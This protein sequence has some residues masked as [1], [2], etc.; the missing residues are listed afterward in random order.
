MLRGLDALVTLISREAVIYLKRVPRAANLAPLSKTSSCQSPV[1]GTSPNQ[2]SRGRASMAAQ[3]SQEPH[4]CG[5][6]PRSANKPPVG[7]FGVHVAPTELG[8]FAVQSL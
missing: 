8:T 5:R 4:A 6:R 2:Q 7:R 3:F 1:L